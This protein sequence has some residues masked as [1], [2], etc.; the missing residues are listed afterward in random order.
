MNA[1]PQNLEVHSLLQFSLS[2]LRHGDSFAN[3]NLHLTNNK[4]FE[5]NYTYFV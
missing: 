2:H 5:L 1:H 3:L 4:A